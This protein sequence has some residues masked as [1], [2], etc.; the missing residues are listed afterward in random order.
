MQ[1]KQERK[2]NFKIYNF[3]LLKK[4]QFLLKVGR[5][6]LLVASW[7]KKRHEPINFKLVQ[8]QFYN[9]FYT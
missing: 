8:N 5:I 7:F 3:W 1:Q 6:F 9:K 2:S 4:K